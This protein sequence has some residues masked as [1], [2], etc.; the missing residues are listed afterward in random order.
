MAIDTENK[1]RSAVGGGISSLVIFESPDA[2]AS[3]FDR[4]HR[5]GLY[6]GITTSVALNFRWISENDSSG[7]YRCE[8]GTSSD[9]AGEQDSVST[10]RCEQDS[11]STY[12]FEGDMITTCTDEVGQVED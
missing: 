10:Y 6:S 3:S 9:Y 7:T 5:V 1:R 12:R 4:R 11:V 8:Q 2:L